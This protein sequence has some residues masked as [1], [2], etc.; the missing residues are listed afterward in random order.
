MAADVICGLLESVRNEME[1][2]EEPAAFPAPLTANAYEGSVCCRIQDK[3]ET[4]YGFTADPCEKKGMLDIFK[5]GWTAKKTGDKIVFE[6]T[7]SNLA[8]QYR[9]SVKKP[10]PVAEAVIDGDEAHP[11]ILDGNFTED[12][13]DCLYLQPLMHHGRKGFH[14]R[15]IRIRE[16]E[17][18]VRPFY[19]VSVIVS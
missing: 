6:I 4:L 12:W 9:K 15:E 13:G 18:I 10:V 8:V 2:Q 19:L 17:Q 3:K 16:A 7:C 5:N 1:Q 14:H 11:V